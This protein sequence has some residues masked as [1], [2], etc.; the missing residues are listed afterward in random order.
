[1]PQPILQC[2]VCLAIC[3]PYPD[4]DRAKSQWAWKPCNRLLNDSHGFCPA[5]YKQE[6]AKLEKLTADVLEVA[7]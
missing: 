1:M 7:E 3:L 6:L 4:R 2:C 5:C